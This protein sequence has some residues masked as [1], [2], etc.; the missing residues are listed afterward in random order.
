MY[1][2]ITDTHDCYISRA[3]INIYIHTYNRHTRLL[4]ISRAGINIY[5]HITDTRLQYINRTYSI[6]TTCSHASH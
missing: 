3:G 5:T 6:I 4:Y 1:T 2:H